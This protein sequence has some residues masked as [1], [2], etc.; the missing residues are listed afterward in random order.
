MK[1]KKESKKVGLRLKIQKIKIM[2]SGPIISWQIDVETMET[3]TDFFFFF[4]SSK[5]TGDGDSS[6]EIKRRLLLGRKGMTNLNSIVK[7][8]DITFRIKF[9]LVKALVFSAVMYGC[10]SWSIKKA[11]QKELML[12]NCG[13]KEDS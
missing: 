8:R 9:H 6:H 7:D 4:L 5:I 11:E 10:E 13:V 2:A 1:L 12:S 3:V